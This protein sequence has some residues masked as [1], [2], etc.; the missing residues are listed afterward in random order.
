MPR[1]PTP[2]T[3]TAN[4]DGEYPCYDIG[5]QHPNGDVEL[6]CDVADP[7]D[8]ELICAAVNGYDTA[9][10]VR[11][12][13]YVGETLETMAADLI[14]YCKAMKISKAAALTEFAEIWDRVQRPE[15]PA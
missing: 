4:P 7:E 9:K 10:G 12:K 5:Y 1:T 11:L 15:T 6:I 13:V 8:A 14:S 2:W 3:V